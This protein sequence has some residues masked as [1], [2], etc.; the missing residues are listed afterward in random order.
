MHGNTEDKQVERIRQAFTS[1]GG[2]PGPLYLL[3]KDHKKIKEG[4]T[5]PPTRPVCNARG[6]PGSRLS[7]LLSV[8]LN[9]ASDSIKAKTECMST[10]EALRS[11]LE[12]NRKI[13][14]GRYGGRAQELVI[15]SMD[16]KALYPSLR[17][18]EVCNVIKEVLTDLIKSQVY[19]I[20]NVDWHEV[21]KYLFI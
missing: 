15:V 12:C 3:V 16:V 20:E 18:K 17:K 19:T 10:E 21:G 9:K 4:E 8:I 2:R 6:G 14:S 13:K 11:I 1:V 5:M 7:N